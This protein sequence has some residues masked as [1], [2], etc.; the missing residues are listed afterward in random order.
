MFPGV[1]ETPLQFIFVTSLSNKSYSYH[2]WLLVI[3]K[4]REKK[5]R[6]GTGF[7]ALQIEVFFLP[8]ITCPGYIKGILRFFYDL[9]RS[10]DTIGEEVGN[11]H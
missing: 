6:K 4:S 10:C 2:L 8:Y 1:L 9:Q 5:E 11:Y 7:N 3:T